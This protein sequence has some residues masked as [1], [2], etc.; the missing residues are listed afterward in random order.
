MNYQMTYCIMIVNIIG[1]CDKRPVLYTCMKIL[2]N[3]GD[4][5][6]IS[7]SSRLM[8]LSDTRD[9]GG[10]YQNTMIAVTMDGI[11]DFF[12]DFKYLHCFFISGVCFFCPWSK[13]YHVAPPLLAVKF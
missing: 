6:L 7:N 1:E 2:Q 4:V 3:I 11:D 13:T 8:R 5:L 9:I 10:H 12:D